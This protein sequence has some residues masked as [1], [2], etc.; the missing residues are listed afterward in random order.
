LSSETRLV[1]ILSEDR[2]QFSRI[3]FEKVIAFRFDN[4]VQAG[5]VENYMWFPGD[6]LS[7]TAF[8][9]QTGC[10]TVKKLIPAAFSAPHMQ[11]A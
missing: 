6:R 4:H 7:A 8:V 10:S 1:F 11:T 3:R 9:P 5:P 2:T